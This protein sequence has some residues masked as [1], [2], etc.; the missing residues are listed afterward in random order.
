MS[1]G[2]G[3][4]IERVGIPFRVGPIAVSEARVVRRDEMKA[5]GKPREER[6]E[7]PRGSWESVQQEKRRRVFRAGLSVKNRQSIDLFRAIKSRVFHGGF[8]SINLGERE[9]FKRKREHQNL[10]YN[11]LLHDRASLIRHFKNHVQ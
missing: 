8:L 4:M 9:Q 11:S 5:I 2:L 1:H 3:D 7:L 6:F 10:R